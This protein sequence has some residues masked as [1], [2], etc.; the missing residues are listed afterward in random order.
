[1]R[2]GILLACHHGLT[3]DELAYIHESFREFA[4]TVAGA[5]VHALGGFPASQSGA[6][7]EADGRLAGP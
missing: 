1:M 3:G 5:G 4:D 7:P 6:K 2:G